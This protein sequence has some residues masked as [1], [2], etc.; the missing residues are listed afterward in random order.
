MKF[1]MRS[2]CS[3]FKF[4]TVLIL[5]C[6]LLGNGYK[7]CLPQATP[8][9]VSHVCSVMSYSLQPTAPRD[10]SHLLLAVDRKK[11]LFTQS[12]TTLW[13]HVHGILQARTMEW[14]AISFSRGSSQT[15]DWAQISCTAGRFFTTWTTREAPWC[16]LRSPSF[17]SAVGQAWFSA[18]GGTPALSGKV[19]LS[20]HGSLLLSS[21]LRRSH[22]TGSH[23]AS[24]V[25]SCWWEASDS[26]GHTPGQ[27]LQLGRAR[28]LGLCPPCGES[29]LPVLL[30]RTCV[31]V[32]TSHLRFAEP[33]PRPTPW[34]SLHTCQCVLR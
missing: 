6:S 30:S 20:Q 4:I 12:C 5:I 7:T 33:S 8:T 15:R 28:W 9:W 13:P 1:T 19:A 29:R 23:P 25:T 10:H 18:P 14:V 22:R 26:S 32:V 24:S 27:R 21:L 31:Q 3:P 17:L 11:M 16:S 34:Q 2:W